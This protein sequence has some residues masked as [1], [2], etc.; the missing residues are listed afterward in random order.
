MKHILDWYNKNTP[1]N[2]DEY[3]KGCLTSAAI[4]AII[5]IALTVAIINIDLKMEKQPISTQDVIQELRDLFRVTNRGFSSEI[6]GI[7]FIDKRQYSASEVHMKLEMYFNDKYII[8]G[9]CKIYPNCVTYTRFEIKSI[10]KLIP[11]YRLMGG[12]TPEKEG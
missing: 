12:Y 7:F 11:N 8:N 2:E 6:D 5:F 3:E 4:I 9:L 10:D 1:Q